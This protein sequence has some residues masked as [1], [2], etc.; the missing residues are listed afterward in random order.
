MVALNTPSTMMMM[1]ALLI[2]CSSFATTSAFQTISSPTT[3]R[4]SS[5]L[6]MAAKA[7]GGGPRFDKT[8][9][10]WIVTDPAVSDVHAACVMSLRLH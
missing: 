4:R 1:T 6:N 2:V 8:T 9:E 10:K 5:L 3:L 7:K